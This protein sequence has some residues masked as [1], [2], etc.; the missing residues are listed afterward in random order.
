MYSI[1][2]AHTANT[3]IHSSTKEDDTIRYLSLHSNQYVR[4]FRGHKSRVVTME[5]SPKD[6]TFLSGSVDD[7]VLL[8][9]L[10]SVNAQVVSWVNKVLECCHEVTRS[11]TRSLYQGCVNIKGSPTVAYDPR[12]LVFAIG[13]ENCVRLYDVRNFDKVC[14]VR[15]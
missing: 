7:K 5:V 13:L 1:K 8:W 11:S 2:F 10:R 6:D 3:V 4:Y 9:D 12:G 15:F 14:A